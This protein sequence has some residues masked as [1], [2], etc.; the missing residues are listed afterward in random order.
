VDT[1]ANYNHP[2]VAQAAIA[3][4]TKAGYDVIVPDCKC[5]GRTLV[6][7]GQP[8]EVLALARHNVGMLAPLARRGLPILGL[9]PSC[10]A[11]FKDDYLDMLPGE[12]AKAVADAFLGV[13]EFLGREAAS[14]QRRFTL[15][16]R[17]T[18]QPNILFHGHCHQKATWSTRDMKQAMTLAG[19]T[20]REIDATCCGMAGAFGYEAEHFEVSKKVGELSVLPAVR[21]ANAD[22]LIVAP[23]TS[24]REQ[25]EHLGDRRPLHPVEVL[26]VVAR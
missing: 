2:R 6:S 10:I 15:T 18:N 21:A 19:Y 7:Q 26:D 4:L 8:G 16:R 12:D 17:F 24:C 3:L 5:C 23:G 22:T 20:V 9:E 13:E 25:I 1:F 11:M 14:G